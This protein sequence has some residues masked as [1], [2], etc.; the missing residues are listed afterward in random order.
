MVKDIKAYC[1]SCHTCKMSK[2][3][4][5]KPYGLLQSLPVLTKPW[6][7]IGMDFIGPLPESK[8]RN[9]AFDMITVVIELL[10]GIVHLIPSKQNY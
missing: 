8:N 10:T 7:G 2:S 1:K 4:N 9:G 5:Q 3:G 6:E